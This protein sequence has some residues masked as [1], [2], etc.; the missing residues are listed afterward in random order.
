MYSAAIKLQVILGKD[1]M[2]RGKKRYDDIKKRLAEYMA[3][4]T[5][6]SEPA[7]QHAI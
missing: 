3:S 1:G 4:N 7:S 5:K 6:I 2:D